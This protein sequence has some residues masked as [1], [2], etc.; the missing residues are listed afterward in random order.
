MP[1]FTGNRIGQMDDTGYSFMS[2]LHFSIH[3]RQIL[4]PGYPAGR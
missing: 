1:I 2:H 4:V 3:D